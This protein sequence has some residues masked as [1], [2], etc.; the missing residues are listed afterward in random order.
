METET[1]Q[2]NSIPALC[3]GLMP[4]P[5]AEQQFVNHNVKKTQAFEG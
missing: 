2:T 4:Y 3:D 1:E 5:S